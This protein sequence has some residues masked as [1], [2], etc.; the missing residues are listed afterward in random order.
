MDEC[1]DVVTTSLSDPS[2]APKAEATV[3][4]VYAKS[5][6]GCGAAFPA[7]FGTDEAL[8]AVFCAKP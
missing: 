1:A 2:Y 4:K 8:A 5:V 3:C 6:G 7:C